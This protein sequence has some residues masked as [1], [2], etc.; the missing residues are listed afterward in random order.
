[1]YLNVDF[2]ESVLDISVFRHL[3]NKLFKERICSLTFH[4]LILNREGPSTSL[5]IMRLATIDPHSQ[6]E[7]T[8]IHK[9]PMFGVNQA[10]F[11]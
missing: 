6:K 9:I 11:D 5:Q 7:H 2:S 8:E 1:M 10:W 4:C 3:F